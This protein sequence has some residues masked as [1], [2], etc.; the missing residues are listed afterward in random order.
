MEN[1]LEYDKFLNRYFKLA[2]RYAHY[3][4]LYDNEYETFSKF[5][6]DITQE[7]INYYI[8]IG[9]TEQEAYIKGQTN[10]LF[11]KRLKIRKSA[12]EDLRGYVESLDIDYESIYKYYNNNDN[13]N[14]NKSITNK[15]HHNIH[16]V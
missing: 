14:D 12:L 2:W 8:N 15:S 13:D 16:S 7:Y 10:S 3:K 11:S 5:K 1:D 9:Y 4:Q 6:L